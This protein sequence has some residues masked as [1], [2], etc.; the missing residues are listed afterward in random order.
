MPTINIKIEV[1][2]ND[3]DKCNYSSRDWFFKRRL[4]CFVPKISG[5]L[6]LK[7]G[8][9]QRCQECLDAEVKGETR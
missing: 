3:C 5:M 4:Y 7:N 1:P 6:T 9:Y 8:K 2:D